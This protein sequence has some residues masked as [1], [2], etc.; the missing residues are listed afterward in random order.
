M[1]DLVCISRDGD[2][3]SEVNKSCEGTLRDTYTRWHAS[4]KPTF[5]DGRKELL[6]YTY[7]TSLHLKHPSPT[8]CIWHI[9]KKR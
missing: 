7:I 9:Y 6:S 4:K 5:L 2:R 8:L 1:A 3:E